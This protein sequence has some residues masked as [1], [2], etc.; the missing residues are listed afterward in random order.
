MRFLSLL[1]LA[2]LWPKFPECRAEEVLILKGDRSR[3]TVATAGGALVSFRL[4]ETGL[5]P[6]N[7]EVP[8]DFEKRPTQ[9]GSPRGHFLC[10]DRWGAPSQ[11]ES[12]NGMPFHGEAPYATWQIS[13]PPQAANGLVTAQMSCQLPLAGLRVERDLQLDSTSAVL[14]VTERVTNTAQLGRVYNLVQHPTIAPPFLD[15]ETLIDTNAREGLVQDTPPPASRRLAPVWPRVTLRGQ[16]RDLRRLETGDEAD[17]VSDVTS[18][19]FRD[20]D[21]L[22]W[23]TASNPRHRLLIGYLWR[24]AE[25]P[26]LNIWR[27]R[28]E[29][30][31]L[32]RGLEFGTTGYHQP[33]PVLVKTG[34]LLDRATYEFLDAGETA[35]RSYLCFVCELPADFAGVA[36]VELR[37]RQIRVSERRESDPRQLVLPTRLSLFPH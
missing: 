22:G 25:Y 26:W 18:F 32:A 7:W 20:H 34:R 9:A 6:L 36:A 8:E 3:V 13:Q 19:V 1:L 24:T 30:R 29:E 11:A 17:P 2:T 12:K 5:N 16:E 35:A 33:F 4:T 15:A 31:R 23:V 21:P 14:Q 37:D 27:Y 28:Q 10:L